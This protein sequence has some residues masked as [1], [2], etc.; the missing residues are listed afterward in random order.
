MIKKF[1]GTMAVVAAMFAGYSAYNAQNE[2]DLTGFTLANI[3]ALASGEAT[4]KEYDC[5]S[6]LTGEGSSISCATCEMETG[7]P[8][9]YHFGSEC[10]R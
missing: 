7:T 1:F 9:W 5:Y 8:P 4:S 6:I 3:E 10:T 2:R